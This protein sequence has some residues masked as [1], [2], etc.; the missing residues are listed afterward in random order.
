[1]T[2]ND[3]GLPDELSLRELTEQFEVRAHELTG[4]GLRMVQ[5]GDHTKTPALVLQIPGMS[6]PVNMFYHV[7]LSDRPT[8]LKLAQDI[9]SY[10]GESFEDKIVERLDRIEKKLRE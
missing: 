8:L 9:Q 6:R 7:F 5:T 10:F 1:M 3:L 2:K 4:S